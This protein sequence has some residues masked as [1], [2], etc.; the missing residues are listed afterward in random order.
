MSE[1]RKLLPNGAYNPL[2]L[3]EFLMN[4]ENLL[5]QQIADELGVPL[6]RVHYLMNKD[7]WASISKDTA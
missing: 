1:H 2:W 3:R 4:N 7:G 5:P 6:H